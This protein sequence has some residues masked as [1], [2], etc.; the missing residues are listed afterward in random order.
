V[1][2]FFQDETPGANLTHSMNYNLG[3]AW[4]VSSPLTSNAFVFGFEM[5]F[6]YKDMLGERG[7]SKKSKVFTRQAHVMMPG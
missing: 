1:D 5:C 3:F 4:G 7:I 6:R 2:W